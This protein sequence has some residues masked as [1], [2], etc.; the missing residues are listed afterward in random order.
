M[1]VSKELLQKFPHMFPLD[2][3]IWERFLAANAE[4]FDG[5]NYDVKVGSGTKDI[6]ARD[7]AFAKMQEILSK[8]RIDAVGMKGEDL[9]IIEVKPRATTQGL[10]QA[11]IY[12]KLYERDFSPKGKIIPVLVTD[13]EMPDVRYL[14]RILEIDYYVV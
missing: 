3:A 12:A 6:E 5:F 13:Y 8:Y 14:T 11:F 7:D 4:A 9:Y 2:I 1:Q 10:G